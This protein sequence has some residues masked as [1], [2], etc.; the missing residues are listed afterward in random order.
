M[1]KSSQIH[2]Y[3]RE[4][5]VLLEYF[6][7]IFSSYTV[8]IQVAGMFLI[9]VNSTLALAYSSIRGLVLG[10]AF[11]VIVLLQYKNYGTVYEESCTTLET[12]R[13]VRSDPWFRRYCKSCRPLRVNM[14]RYYFADRTLVLTML[15]II[16]DNTANL[17]IGVQQS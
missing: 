12:W 15:S 9:V 13:T 6:N 4:L 8:T 14:G 11:F 2:C 16:L 10:S 3:S 7:S 1:K 17:T 5:Q